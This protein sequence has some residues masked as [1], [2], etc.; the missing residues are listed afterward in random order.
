MTKHLERLRAP[1]AAQGYTGL[2]LAA[3]AYGRAAALA[4][5][6]L[7]VRIKL[8]RARSLGR[9]VF[10]TGALDVH[11]ERGAEVD[12]GTDVRFHA[13][14][15]RPRLSVRHRARL[16]IGD[17]CLLNGCIIA[18]NTEVRIGSGV[19][20]GPWAHLMD[21]DFHGVGERDGAAASGPIVIGDDA[22][23]ATRAM[24]LKGVTVGR[25]AVVAAGAVVTK[26]VPPYTVVA[27][28]P[29]RVVRRLTPAAA[30]PPA[31]PPPPRPAPRSR[32]LAHLGSAG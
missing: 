13:D 22:W 16:R 26:D 9:L 15:H 5:A 27:G 25:G 23:L 29:A 7:R 14:I 11:L 4:V 21:G 19:T 18:A 10:A 28:V 8:R 24:V 12:I 2:G 20:L 6:W 3:R 1:Y 30:T 32:P 31:A 17:G